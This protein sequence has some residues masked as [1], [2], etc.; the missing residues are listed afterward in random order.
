M[1]ELLR[2]MREKKVGAP[3]VAKLLK[4]PDVHVRDKALHAIYQAG[5]AAKDAVPVLVGFLRD[6]DEKTR[7]LAVRALGG[8]GANAKTRDAA[9]I[10]RDAAPIVVELLKD[11]DR[12]VRQ[13]AAGILAASFGFV[14]KDVITPRLVELIND[15][16]QDV[17]LN[18]VKALG[19][20]GAR[21]KDAGPIL[22]EDLKD[23]NK[24]MR[25]AAAVALGRIRPV[26]ENAV[27][28]LV[29]LLRTDPEGEVRRAAADALARIW[30]TMDD[31]TPHLAECL[32]D[33]DKRVR[34]VGFH[35][36]RRLGPRAKYA[37]PALTDLLKASDNEVSTSAKDALEHIAQMITVVVDE[38][39]STTRRHLE[40]LRKILN[41]R[42]KTS[43][44]DI[45]VQESIHEAI[46]H[47][48]RL[49]RVSH[50]NR[51][52][53]S[54]WTEALTYWRTWA[55]LAPAIGLFVLVAVYLVKRHG[56]G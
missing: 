14:T 18:A 40:K 53:D 25:R 15:S 20:I 48:E 11:P 49:E 12:L 1:K 9:P 38:P 37:I 34:E 17:R 5:S 6:P 32:K 36:L 47:L 46:K 56:K 7:L 39:D 13:A 10:L 31:P 29:G 35:A 4:D 45:E 8:M 3:A 27:P 21:T 16:D 41:T 28:R 55:I 22:L 24:S 33:P 43:A 51:D 19:G 30:P 54:L 42:G 2:L 23:S 44:R 26:A 50:I 52:G